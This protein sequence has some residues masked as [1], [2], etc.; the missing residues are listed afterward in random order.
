[1]S[2]YFPS[3]CHSDVI[4]KWWFIWNVY[5]HHST[6]SRVILCRHYFGDDHQTR[7]LSDCWSYWQ[8]RNHAQRYNSWHPLR[9]P[10]VIS[11]P[12]DTNYK[13]IMIKFPSTE[14]CWRKRNCR[15]FL[16]SLI[17]PTK[18]QT[19][20]FW[21]VTV[22]HDELHKWRK[23]ACF[24]FF[25]SK[26]FL[27]SYWVVNLH[28]DRRMKSHWLFQEVA[29]HWKVRS[30]LKVIQTETCITLNCYINLE[31]SV[32]SRYI[33][34]KVLSFHTFKSTQNVPLT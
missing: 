15:T 18:F 27:V 12:H 4:L 2:W 10:Q 30:T 19:L 3:H 6:L 16:D 8:R 29:S 21:I 33:Q 32:N 23:C 11:Q 14:L 28:H 26:V 20:Y 31:S 34:H 7:S 24:G 9:P 17:T 13:F 22:K 1:M 25:S 5:C